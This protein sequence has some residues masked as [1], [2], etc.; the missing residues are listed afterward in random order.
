MILLGA[1][2]LG[3]KREGVYREWCSISVS[4]EFVGKFVS[5]ATRLRGMVF[6]KRERGKARDLCIVTL[7][8]EFVGHYRVR[9]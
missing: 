2:L 9:G 7:I 3:G 1:V 4:A 5:A 6:D 8:T